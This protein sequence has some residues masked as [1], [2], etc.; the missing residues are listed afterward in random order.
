MQVDVGSFEENLK[1]AS[2]EDGK[3]TIKCQVIRHWFVPKLSELREDHAKAD[4]NLLK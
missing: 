3:S 1:D 4:R 2:L